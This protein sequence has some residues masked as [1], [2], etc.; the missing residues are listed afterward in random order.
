MRIGTVMVG[1]HRGL[2][3]LGGS[4]PGIVSWSLSGIDPSNDNIDGLPTTVSTIGPSRSD[5]HPNGTIEIDHVVLMSHDPPRTVAALERYGFEVRRTRDPG[6]GM[7]QTFFKLR[8]VVL[9]LIGPAVPDEL[10]TPAHF[11]GLAF[12]VDDLDATAAFLGDKLG[13]VKDAVQPGRQIATLRKEA[14]AGLAVAFMS[15]GRAAV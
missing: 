3:P 10:D 7:S 15:P 11:Y 5:E 4:P 14:S 12:T 6:N 2:Q 8:E 13:R 9:E 1:F